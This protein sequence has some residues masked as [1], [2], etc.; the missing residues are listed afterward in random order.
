MIN[1]GWHLL[2][3]N[4]F[5][6]GKNPLRNKSTEELW[7]KFAYSVLYFGDVRLLLFLGVLKP[8]CAT[9]PCNNRCRVPIRNPSSTQLRIELFP[10]NGSC[11]PSDGKLLSVD[12][13]LGNLLCYTRHTKCGYVVRGFIIVLGCNQAIYHKVCYTFMKY[14]YFIY[15]WI[16]KYPLQ[17]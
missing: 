3:M 1:K 12:F 6:W 9:V 5:H 7:C 16:I 14:I 17:E 15:V 8:H 13:K 10:G 11:K 4:K 2:I